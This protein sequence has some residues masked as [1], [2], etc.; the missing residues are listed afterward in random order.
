MSAKGNDKTTPVNVFNQYLNM[1]MDKL[2]LTTGAGLIG[3]G[4]VWFLY[5][6]FQYVTTTPKSA[7]QQ[8]IVEN[9]F[10]QAQNGV[11]ILAIGVLIKVTKERV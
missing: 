6:L 9:F 5:G 1:A 2:G 7:P 8:M 3:I 4:A 10:N 11:I